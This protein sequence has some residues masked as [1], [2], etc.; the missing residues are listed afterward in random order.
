MPRSS[1]DGKHQRF[2]G[3]LITCLDVMVKNG[4]NL[5]FVVVF[6]CHFCR[7]FFGSYEYLRPQ[8]HFRSRCSQW[9]GPGSDLN[10]LIKKQAARVKTK[11]VKKV[12]RHNLAELLTDGKVGWCRYHKTSDQTKWRPN[13][14]ILCR[15]FSSES[16]SEFLE[17]ISRSW[18]LTSR[19][20][21]FGI[22][23]GWLR[24]SLKTG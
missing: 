18:R 17:F 15:P 7:F 23:T 11:A 19:N 16:V 3:R 13:T 6:G 20:A 12:V 1:K 2:K 24:T 10:F 5:V 21:S 22:T 4:Q 14:S 8:R 9:L